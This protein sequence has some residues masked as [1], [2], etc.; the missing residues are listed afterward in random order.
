MRVSGWGCCS[1]SVEAIVAIVAVLKT[2]RRMCRWIGAPPARLRFL[3][4]DAAPVAAVTPRA[5]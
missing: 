3:L 2:G 5:G 1:R 4:E